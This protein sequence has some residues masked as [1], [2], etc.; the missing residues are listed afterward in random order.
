MALLE[1]GVMGCLNWLSEAN[2][3]I[4]P[5]SKVW[6]RRPKSASMFGG[7]SSW[8]GCLGQPEA[9]AKH[10]RDLCRILY[11]YVGAPKN[12]LCHSG[13]ANFSKSWI[14]P[15]C[16]CETALKNQKFKQ[17][18]SHYLL[19]GFFSHCVTFFKCSSQPQNLETYLKS[20]SHNHCLLELGPRFNMK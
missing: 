6:F 7:E 4:S 1:K 8:A 12:T 16:N 15:S 11:V 3:D 10:P 14:C 20:F 13:A 2:L 19:C 5:L 18:S 17:C 9:G